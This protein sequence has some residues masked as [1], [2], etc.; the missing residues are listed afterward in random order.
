M[1]PT[2]I[3]TLRRRAETTPHRLALEF[4]LSETE[5]RAL[6]YAEL[7]RGARAVA[8]LIQQHADRGDRVLLLHQPG[9]D[10]VTAFFG[11]LYSGA[12][13]VPVYPPL[14]TNGLE[15]VRAI[16][17]DSGAVLALVD[18]VTLAAIDERGGRPDLSAPLVWATTDDAVTAPEDWRD[19][20]A[21]PDD[22]AFLQY[23][24][25]STGTPK[26]VM[27]S[28]ANL[29]HNSAT[30]GRALGLDENDRAVSWLPPYHDMGLIGGILQPVHTGF[31]CT[32]LS[33]MTF[34]H[35]PMRW[36]HALSRTRATITA[37]PDFAYA[38][39]LRRAVPGDHDGLDLSALRHALVGAEPV[40]RTTLD[41][42]AEA[43]HRDGFRRSAFYPCYGLAEAT[44]FVT[45]RADPA[46]EPTTL[47][48]R[49]PD[50]DDGRAVEAEPG[51]P[52]VELTACGWAHHQDLV[53][54][55][56]PAT[57]EPRPPGAVGEIWVSG[58]T[59]ARG[60]WNLPDRTAESF[61]AEARGHR[62]RTFLR[63]GDLGFRHGTELYVTGRIKDLIIVRGR[64]L[65]PSDIE[66]TAER[67]HP[68][69][70]PGRGAALAVDDGT[71]EQVVL[72]HEVVR[73]FREEDG[74]LVAAAVRE[75]VAA[76][77]GLALADVVLV[78]TGKIPRTSSGKVRRSE[79]RT[80]WLAG[81]FRR[82]GTTEPAAQPA[83]VPAAPAEAVPAALAEAVAAALDTDPGALDA[84]APLVGQ[85]L[86][87]LRAV[88]L[89]TA[90]LE[91][92]GLDVSTTRFLEGLTL[93]DLAA[94]PPGPAAPL[95]AAAA[96]EPAADPAA[97][98]P[99]QERMWL[100]DQMGAGAAYHVAGGLR[101]HG[102][103]DE[104]L[105]ERCLTG[106]FD[107]VPL[108]RSVF[109]AT[110]DGTPTVT[111]RPTADVFRLPSR[112][113]RTPG[114]D[115]G[116]GPADEDGVDGALRA[117][118]AEP[119]DLASG[120]L[121]RLLLL[122][123][124]PRD[125]VLG[126]AA[127]HAVLD[128]WSLGLLLRR[129]GD[130]YR[131]GGTIEPRP[132]SVPARAPWTEETLAA[133]RHRLAGA[134][135]L[136]LPTD[137]P[138][139]AAPTWN[140]ASLPVRIPAGLVARIRTVAADRG[141]TPFMVLLAAF[142]VLLSRWSGQD[143]VVVGT[144][145]AGRDR[146]GA[147]TAIGMLTDTLPLRVRTGQ[148]DFGTVVDEVRAQCLAAYGP[149]RPPYDEI[150]RAVT[151]RPADG[152]A[153]L[154]RALL[155]LQNLPLSPWEAHGVRAEPFELPAPGAQFEL[156][157]H[158]VPQDD[159]SLDGHAVY[160]A[161]LFDEQTVALLLAGL[162]VLL[163]A[164][165]T[166][167][168]TAVAALPALAPAEAE[169]IARTVADGGPAELGDGLVHEI[170]ERL[171]RTAPGNPAVVWDGGSLTYGELSAR[172][173]A[174][175]ARLRALGVDRDEP[176]AICLPRSPELIVAVYAVL[177]AGAAYLPLDTAH[178]AARLVRQIGSSG[179]RLLI[180][181]LPGLTP[182][183][184]TVLVDPAGPADSGPEPVDGGPRGNGTGPSEH[185]RVL[186]GHLANVLFTSGSTGEP[187]AVMTTHGA[188][189]NQLVWF[190]HAYG[191]DAR[192]AV[193]HKTPVSFDV[194]GLELLGP[195]VAGAAVVLA[196]P[197]GHRDP[198][199]LAR[200]IVRHSVTTCH[201]V[202][203]MLQTF[204]EEPEA[205]H[206]A[207]TLRRIVCIGEELA[208]ALAER[209]A[210]LLPGVEL[211]NLYGPT[212]AAI[213]V[214]AQAV[215]P[216]T[217]TLSRVPIGRAIAGTR[218]YVFDS[219]GSIAPPLVPGEL[220]IGGT[221]PARGYLGRPALTAERFVPDP[222]QPGAR[223]Y[224]TGDRA[225][226]RPDGTF[227][228][229][230]RLDRQLKIRGQRV[231]P[232][233]IEAVLNRHPL[234]RTSV[235]EARPDTSGRPRLLA[236]VVPAGPEHPG[237]A[238]LRDHLEQTLPSGLVP[239]AMTVLAELPVGPHGKLDR[240]ALPDPVPAAD[241]PQETVAPRDPVERKMAAIWSEVLGVPV[242]SVT[243]DFFR[244]GGHSLM[245][246]RVAM[247]VRDTFGVGLSTGELLSGPLTVE[248]LAALVQ[249]R[250][251]TETGG[252]EVDD[253]LG[254]LSGLSDDEVTAL[255]ARETDGE[256]RP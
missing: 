146:P 48:L 32:L 101:L 38:E 200:L 239:D 237:Q 234:V 153:P 20:R 185:A 13:A 115:G 226:M 143:D 79:C 113:L 69:L 220:Y 247:R 228:Y 160:A 24:S 167:P 179:A 14:G 36:L 25:G 183:D 93:R 165:L 47:R 78:R 255:L 181:S 41:A 65:Y 147:D 171:A 72:V 189:V 114:A 182:P 109:P 166:A 246:T 175:A 151:D 142:G 64:N 159:G 141:A 132:S 248:R 206:T 123:Q 256:T 219:S 73:G 121:V 34:L 88:R 57:G 243:A 49:R 240:A 54:I 245:A 7:D 23:T 210:A 163:D 108:L 9:P 222:Y 68:F 164:A 105:L 12:I 216:A 44:L 157:V 233:E 94:M 15:R 168:A 62:G 100:L 218:L 126:V 212:E 140:G 102:P 129:L 43:F 244:L 139:P 8:A 59:V 253:V 35:Q 250:Q 235:V 242:P 117:L 33:P 195:L 98:T 196:R 221:A 254:W 52:A 150:V 133:W 90:I 55:V 169:R 26:G 106:L 223:L 5:V 3:E 61:A 199:Y 89:R 46:A 176:V 56:D 120:P 70:H 85:G 174:L 187:K 162:P 136:E 125:W 51:E 217:T 184:G 39:V 67:A 158:L 6:D 224:R 190:Q 209:C 124:G 91:T 204:L 42:F 58:P 84:H 107:E 30:I 127:H 71:T 29:V 137:R 197:D 145:A 138:V 251:L 28:H 40:R 111:V 135:P 213:D 63:T 80:R 17:A 227:E 149:E 144:V 170:V 198:H 155:A 180:G 186:P 191:L 128:G 27:L 172:A 19:P 130:A 215:T 82:V 4:E 76:E 2:F 81:T 110:P 131:N 193:L 173:H 66:M 11:C 230:G 1:N 192:E 188:L 241:F 21:L 103:L 96:A 87:S 214:S 202:P 10:Y 50:M 92:F 203:S 252:S 16:A 148:A 225:R 45:G 116:A 22:L 86:D 119:F 83:T 207:R 249:S 231:E 18:T 74:P 205:A 37:A 211:H 156:S 201:F 134:Q 95:T 53:L 118:A 194:A 208:P 122:R 236:W 229:L 238:A 99:D 75:A 152:R 232:G 60:Y 178:P 154:V 104:T 161:D 97:V 77:H 112:D 177:L 31:P